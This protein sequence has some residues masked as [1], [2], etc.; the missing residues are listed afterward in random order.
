MENIIQ[1]N[2]RSINPEAQ[3]PEVGFSYLEKDI[4]DFSKHKKSAYIF[5][6]PFLNPLPT[7]HNLGIHI[8]LDRAFDL[9]FVMDGYF[10]GERTFKCVYVYENNS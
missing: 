7:V 5:H 2:L 10:G 4:I 6:S 1:G 8:H 3:L 9:W